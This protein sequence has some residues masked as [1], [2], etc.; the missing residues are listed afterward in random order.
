MPFLR[1]QQASRIAVEQILREQRQQMEAQAF[2]GWQ[3]YL[4]NPFREGAPMTFPEWMEFIGLNAPKT[5][6]M[7]AEETAALRV[8]ALD[9]AAAIV[10]KDRKRRENNR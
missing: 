1:F 2:I 8:K 9:R 10:A 3:G 7:S 6:Q 4:V 5:V